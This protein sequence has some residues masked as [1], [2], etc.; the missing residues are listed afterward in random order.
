MSNSNGKARFP[1]ERASA[2]FSADPPRQRRPRSASH[3]ADIQ[4]LHC[5]CL[6]ET[7]DE[8]PSGVNNPPSVN[9]ELYCQPHG[10]ELL[11]DVYSR[12]NKSVLVRTVVFLLSEM[13]FD[14]ESALCAVG[15]L[16][17]RHAAKGFEDLCYR[18][19]AVMESLEESQDLE[20]H[21]L[22]TR[23]NMELQIFPRILL[24]DNV[25][26]KPLVVHQVRG[27]PGQAR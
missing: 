5:G 17:G 23:R 8:T 19:Q 1:T 22:K 25:N 11:D 26:R 10:R 16:R 3:D 2:S 21:D 9:F 14:F 20:M 7:D 12:N 4:T 15:T 27:R 24:S 18:D 6:P 13:R